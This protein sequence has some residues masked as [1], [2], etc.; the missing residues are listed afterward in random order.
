MRKK[1]PVG[2]FVFILFFTFAI[3][4]GISL[5]AEVFFHA[6]SIII[7]C[8][9]I[10]FLMLLAFLGDIVAVAVAYAEQAPFNAM[11]SRKIKGA[12]ACIKLIKNS[13]K[14]SSILSDVLGD[15]CGIISGVVGASL[16]LVIASAASFTAFEQVLAVVTVTATI[17]A[18]T[19][20]IKSLAKKIA[21]KNSIKIVFFVGKFFSIFGKK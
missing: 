20:S 17:A 14:V 21:I 8:I 6:D 13:D 15:V 11:A 7:C 10:F 1:R 2:W 3:A 9:I 16:S 19:V 5:A 18:I 4:F 12:K